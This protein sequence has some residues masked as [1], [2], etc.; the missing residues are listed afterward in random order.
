MDVIDV[1]H[2][3]PAA[4]LVDGSRQSAWIE[5]EEDGGVGARITLDLPEKQD[6]RLGCILNGYAKTSE[7]YDANGSVRVL[8]VATASGARAAALPGVTD[9]SVFDYQPLVFA[10]V[11]ARLRYVGDR[12]VSARCRS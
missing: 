3:Y 1:G 11:S 2:S 4:N 9:A 5:E 8:E 6:V 7:L 10:P 12:G